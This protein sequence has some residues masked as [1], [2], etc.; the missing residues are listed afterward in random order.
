MILSATRL[1]QGC[2]SN[3]EEKELKQQGWKSHAA[4]LFVN[5]NTEL[6]F[7][8][9]PICNSIHLG[10]P[11]RSKLIRVFR[12]PASTL[13]VRRDLAVSYRPASCNSS[14]SDGACS[15][16]LS[17]TCSVSDTACWF[18]RIRSIR[19]RP[20]SPSATTLSAAARARPYSA[21]ATT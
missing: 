2:D 14:S 12:T 7:V 15:T 3:H 18:V 9:H 17:P 1:T 21:C 16:P 19:E 6:V 4:R 13:D 5:S 11:F 10:C 8:L 20:S